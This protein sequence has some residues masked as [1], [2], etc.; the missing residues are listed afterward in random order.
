MKLL[1]I[2]PTYNELESAP[3]LISQVLAIKSNFDVLVIDDNSPDGT[4][5]EVIRRF[6]L[7]SKFYYISRFRKAGLGSAYREG[8]KFAIKNRYDFVIQMDADGS[9]RIE[10]LIKI[11]NTPQNYNLVIGSRYVKG[12]K[13]SQWNLN[14]RILSRVANYVAKKTLSL[15][16][17]DCTSGFK[18][19]S[20]EH[21]KETNLLESKLNG[22]EFQIEISK[23]FVE[24]KL[25]FVEIPIELIN[26]NAGK[27]KMTIGIATRTSLQII[28]WGI[29]SCGMKL[30]NR[31]YELGIL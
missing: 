19:I 28:Y 14:R 17:N 11:L 12:G 2:I 7:N 29:K 4:L 10:D 24:K 15:P 31:N 30:K 22:Y 1:I 18:R 8:F 6:E 21:L 16:V 20:I 27:S 23:E 5:N 9:H 13:V 26:R 3:H 25:N